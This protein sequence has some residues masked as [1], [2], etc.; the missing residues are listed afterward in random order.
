MLLFR[1]RHRNLLGTIHQ[2]G[3]SIP[4]GV[5]LPKMGVIFTE[6]GCARTGYHK[7]FITL[8]IPTLSSQHPSPAN[9]PVATN[10]SLPRN[11][12]TVSSISSILCAQ[13]IDPAACIQ[14]HH[15]TPPPSLPHPSPH[16]N[17]ESTPQSSKHLKA[18]LSR[19]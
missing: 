4:L 11:S 15:P 19:H 16:P 2:K 17:L 18:Y 1:L 3:W 7:K 12:P 6:T 13:S 9:K 5:H 14:I 8:P 10:P